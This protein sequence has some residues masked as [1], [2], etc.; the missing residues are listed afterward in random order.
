MP[1]ATD[2]QMVELSLLASQDLGLIDLQTSEIKCSW[3]AFIDS[4]EPSLSQ[5][6]HSDSGPLVTSALL[7]EAAA[8]AEWSHLAY[9]RWQ[10][11][12]RPPWF[13]VSN[14]KKWI[15]LQRVNL[16]LNNQVKNVCCLLNPQNKG[17]PN[18]NMCCSEPLMSSQG[19][20]TDSKVEGQES[21]SQ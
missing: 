5:A 2:W 17:F 8:R 10:T 14:R 15:L 13:L 19:F 4:Y 16:F 7:V 6:L 1:A 21:G 3:C 9:N 18:F 12:W 11:T 20:I